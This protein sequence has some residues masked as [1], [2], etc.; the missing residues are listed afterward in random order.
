[1]REITIRGILLSIVLAIILAASNT[2]LALKI[3]ILTSASIPAAVIAMGILRFFKD[4]SILEKNLVQTGA[5]AGEAIA[6]GIVYTIPALVIIQFWS[7]FSYWHNFFIAVIG[8]VLGILFS[9]PLRRVLMNEPNLKFPEAQA[10]TKTLQMA[11]NKEIGIKEMLTGGLVGA[12]LE[13]AQSG[14]QIVASS[15]QG[16]IAAGKTLIGF[17][18]GF[19]ATLIGAGYLIGF[20]VGLSLLIGAVT[21]WLVIVPV[22]SGMY[23]LSQPGMSPT[24]S[25]VALWGN[26]VRFVGIGA[27]LAAG[28]WTLLTLLKPIGKGIAASFRTIEPQETSSLQS[29]KDLPFAY[30]ALGILLCSIAGYFLL[31]ALLPLTAM[32]LPSSLGHWIF[33]LSLAFVIVVGFIFA[34]ICGYFSGLVGVS[35]SPGSAVV[36]G[37]LLLV[38]IALRAA[39]HAYHVSLNHDMVINACAIVIVLISVVTGIACISNDN[40]QDLKVGH[41]V[42]STPWKQQFM[43]LVGVLAASSV[44]PLLMQLLFKVYGIGGVMPHTGMDPSKMLPAPVPSVLAY[45]TQAVFN[46][47]LPLNMLLLGVGIIAGF[48]LLNFLLRKKSFRLSILG[49]AMGLYLPLSSSTP[50][51]IGSLIAILLQRMAAKRGLNPIQTQRSVVLACGIVAGA[52]LMDVALAIPFA[53]SGNPNVLKVMPDHL[54]SLAVVLGG[55]SLLYLAKLFYKQTIRQ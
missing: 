16:F 4:S 8:G 40:I 55:L 47:N 18:T 38:S 33:G 49:I 17:G 41:L 27:M 39:F 48:V 6:G 32:S 23:H 34:A 45:V 1:M 51:F 44:I 3:G 29:E 36:I 9:I 43:L 22:L 19:S 37:G 50:L 35:A 52:A 46:G 12:A 15:V 28:T 13:F 24:D 54:H 25:A 26:Y 30:V 20:N 53:I 14:L 10:I 21:G 7:G 31:E 2:Y 11:E 42:G 5:S